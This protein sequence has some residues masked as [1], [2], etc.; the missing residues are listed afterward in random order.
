[1]LLLAGPAIAQP[2]EDATGLMPDRLMLLPDVRAVEVHMEMSTIGILIQANLF[3]GFCDARS[4]AWLSKADQ[5]I[6]RAA[7]IIVREKSLDG[8]WAN[9]SRGVFA[10]VRV[11][12][13]QDALRRTRAEEKHIFCARVVTGDALRPLD[14]LMASGSR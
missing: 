8:S 2:N 6:E 7:E 3:A 13:Y 9:Y 10:G 5:L 11:M 12:A 1:M 4:Q 14:D